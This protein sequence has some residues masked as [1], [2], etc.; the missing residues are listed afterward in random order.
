MSW[1][2]SVATFCKKDQVVGVLPEGQHLPP[3]PLLAQKLGL[4]GDKS[5]EG[6]ACVCEPSSSWPW[7]LP[8]APVQ[9]WLRV[10]L[11]ASSKEP[12]LPAQQERPCHF[13]EIP[14]SRLLRLP[15]S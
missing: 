10:H 15:D 5:G 4:A 2:T 6:C 14:E 3:A 1:L 12:C 8:P 13:S 9:A 7:Q 11:S